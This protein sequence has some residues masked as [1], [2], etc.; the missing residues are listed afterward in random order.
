MLRYKTDC[1]NMKWQEF[2][3]GVIFYEDRRVNNA[4]GDSVQGPI[5]GR[6]ESIVHIVALNFNY[7]F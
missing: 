4:V 3:D 1:V 6:Y 2:S 7:R 5:D